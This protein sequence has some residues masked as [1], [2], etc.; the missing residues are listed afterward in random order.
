MIGMR[1]KERIESRGLEVIDPMDRHRL[2]AGNEGK[3]NTRIGRVV[4][5]V[6]A[7]EEPADFVRVEQKPLVNGFAPA[8]GLGSRLR[9]RARRRT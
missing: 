4:R 1:V 6:D 8:F 9:L 7:G 3:N 2:F 5:V